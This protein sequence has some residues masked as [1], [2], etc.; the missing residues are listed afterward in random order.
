[1][2]AD[3]ANIGKALLGFLADGD[4]QTTEARYDGKHLLAG[5]TEQ[6]GGSAADKYAAEIEDLERRLDREWPGWRRKQSMA[7]L[8]QRNP[9]VLATIKLW[10][11]RRRMILIGQGAWGAQ[12]RWRISRGRK[13]PVVV[14]VRP[15]F[16]RRVAE[17]Q[18]DEA[19]DPKTPKI[20]LP[21]LAVKVGEPL[22]RIEAAMA[23]YD[24]AV[25]KNQLDHCRSWLEANPVKPKRK[26][27]TKETTDAT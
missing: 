26:K 19:I 12:V 4:Y 9:D 21:F 3:A 20:S 15:A 16:A 1:M 27:K 7:P 6:Y 22:E 11:T 24:P 23:A 18:P 13:H 5:L 10:L 17:R 2:T 8:A 25:T 14:A